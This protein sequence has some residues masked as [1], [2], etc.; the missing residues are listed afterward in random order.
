MCI[1]E[2]NEAETMRLFKEE[3]RF[4]KSKEVYKNC[5]Q[6]GM[7]EEDALAISGLNDQEG[8]LLSPPHV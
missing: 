5:I 7:S 4:E 3:G 6:R 1:T 2:Y 8:S